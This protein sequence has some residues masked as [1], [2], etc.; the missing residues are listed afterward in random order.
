ML[1]KMLGRTWVNNQ[2]RGAQ[3]E[4]RGVSPPPGAGAPALQPRAL[5]GA[6]ALQDE[7][8]TQC[9]HPVPLSKGRVRH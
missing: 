5:Y 9:P 4:V 8:A 3:G 2:M 7:R 6:S 1:E